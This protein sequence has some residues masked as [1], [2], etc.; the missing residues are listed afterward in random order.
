[1][2]RLRRRRG[3][4]GTILILVVGLALAAATQTALRGSAAQA[5][6]STSPVQGTDVSVVQ[7]SSINWADV[8]GSERFVAIKATEGNYYADAD[9][10]P[11][12]T[13]AA[14]AGLYVMPYVFANPYGSNSAT[15]T[16]GNGWGNVQADYAWKTISAQ[17]T[18]AYKSSALMLPVAVDLEADP[19]VSKEPNSNQ[20]YGLAPTAMVNW[21]NSFF[22]EMIKDSG[23]VPVIYTST[24]WW[25]ACTGNSGAF[26]TAPLWLASWGVSVPSIPSVWANETFWQYS[27]SGQ[28]SGIGG[29][30]DLDSLGPTRASAVNTAIPAEQIETLSS[31]AAQDFPSGYSATGLPTGV[32]I[33]ATGQITGTPSAI[34]QYSV[35]VTP[36]AGAAPA[37]MSFPWDVHGAVTVSNATSRSS[38]EGAPVSVA[39]TASGPDQTAGFAPSFSATGLPPGLT[40]SSTSGRIT[41]SPTSSGTFKVTVTA[42]DALGGSGTASFTWTVTPEVTCPGIVWQGGVAKVQPVPCGSSGTQRVKPGNG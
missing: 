36:P 22:S 33:S 6:T 29:A 9:Y 40:I 21:L 23:K 19:Y 26:K 28:V 1:V 17:T 8:A 30:V 18:P 12:V 14:A 7:G 39:I 13:G 5:T 24:S 25:D 2:I 41:G 11:D 34:G 20:C 42:A 38:D 27:D 31:M 16:A 32:S 3:I 35:T 4:A 10:A 37:S 15:P